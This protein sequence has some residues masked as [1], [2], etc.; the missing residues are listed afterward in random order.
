MG[1]DKSMARASSASSV[2]KLGGS[3]SNLS[4]A[5]STSSVRASSSGGGFRPVG[6]A[7]DLSSTTPKADLLKR[8]RKS[9]CPFCQIVHDPA[10][11]DRKLYSDDRVTVFWDRTP[12]ARVHLLV[13]PNKHI[14]NTKE[15]NKG[16]MDHQLL[17][18]MHSI[19]KV[20]LKKESARYEECDDFLVSNGFRYGFHVPPFTSVDHLH[21]HC[22]APPFN[23][24]WLCVPLSIK[25]SPKYPWYEPIEDTLK[26]IHP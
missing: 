7:A 19:G 18:H 11:A 17:V 5:A 20:I 22:L 9:D 14:K 4:K 24:T 6:T 8:Q 16:T 13:V 12:K 1:K 3:T 2:S 26:K 15:L 23:K 10:Y 25:Y 21:L